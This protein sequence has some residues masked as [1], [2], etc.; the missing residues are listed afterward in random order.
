MSENI[1]ITENVLD[2][3][4]EQEIFDTK[5][6]PKTFLEENEILIEQPEDIQAMR[7]AFMDKA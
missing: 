5:Q 4:E 6:I 7:D 2:E 1:R 3:I